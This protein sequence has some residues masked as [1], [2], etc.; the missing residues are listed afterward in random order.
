MNNRPGNDEF[1][2][3]YLNYVNMVPDGNIIEILQDQN[4]NTIQFL[5]EIT[6]QQALFRYGP[7]KWSIKEVLG[8]M[9][10]TEQIMA[11]RL[12]CIARGETV[13]L[14]GFDETHY[15]KN[16]SFDQQSISELLARFAAVRGATIHLLAGLTEE[17]W[18]KRGLAN[19]SPVTV[20]A[21][22]YIIAGH[23]RH[24][25]GII[26]DRYISSSNYPRS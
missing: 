1:N 24:H 10:D 19:E 26:K 20:R 12:L 2:D 9:T 18:L 22:A 13:S 3:Y 7:D 17:D 16:A 25:L 14:P 6:D 23:E 5:E 11:Y 15:V 4:K 8:H 21:I